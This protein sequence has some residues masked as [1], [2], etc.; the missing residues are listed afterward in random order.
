MVNQ[1]PYSG[2]KAEQFTFLDRSWILHGV[3][4]KLNGKINE[5]MQSVMTVSEREIEKAVF[6]LVKSTYV[7]DS[8]KIFPDHPLTLQM[9]VTCEIYRKNG[10]FTFMAQDIYY[11]LDYTVIN[12]I[13]ED[14]KDEIEKVFDVTPEGKTVVEDIILGNKNV[15][16]EEE[17]KNLICT[18]VSTLYDKYS[19]DVLEDVLTE[20]MDYYGK[21]N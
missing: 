3:H 5:K 13:V 10:K 2:E 20:V 1:I 7:Y 11:T 8:S 4:E 21:S 14:F 19:D 9:T 12:E 18:L 15:Y 6:H 17:K 16:S